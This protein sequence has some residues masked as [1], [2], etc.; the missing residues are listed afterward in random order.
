MFA[1]GQQLQEKMQA[2]S[3]NI[4]ATQLGKQRADLT[5]QADEIQAKINKLNAQIYDSPLGTE[6]GELQK[7][8]KALQDKF[9]AMVAP[10]LAAHG[11]PD[12]SL[13]P[14]LELKNCAPKP[15]QAQATH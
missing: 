13:T 2:T 7:Q 12:G 3:D 8:G 6:M 4:A 15:Q 9:T 10:I 5:K 1:E 14:A 11:C